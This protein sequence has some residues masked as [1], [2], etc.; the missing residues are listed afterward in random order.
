MVLNK[1]ADVASVDSNV[2]HYF[3]KHNPQHKDSLNVIKSFGPMPVYPVVFNSR[4]PG[5]KSDLLK[6]FHIHRGEHFNIT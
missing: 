4:L 2:L 6:L 1:M 3:L 5:M